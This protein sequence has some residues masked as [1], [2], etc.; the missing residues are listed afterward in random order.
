MHHALSQH[1]MSCQLLLC[2]L[3]SDL[4]SCA[5]GSLT[6][7]APAGLASDRKDSFMMNMHYITELAESFKLHAPFFGVHLLV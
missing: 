6:V 3:S 7:Q 5:E 4:S 1:N 2:R